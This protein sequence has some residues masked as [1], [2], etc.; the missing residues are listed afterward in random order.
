[1]AV[2]WS[3]KKCTTR[4]TPADEE[5]VA[6]IYTLHDK[7]GTVDDVTV[8]VEVGLDKRY[9]AANWLTSLTAEGY[10]PNDWT[11]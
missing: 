6:R 7:N 2:N 9:D 11:T 10:T 8:Q 5:H 1:M 3:I 4:A